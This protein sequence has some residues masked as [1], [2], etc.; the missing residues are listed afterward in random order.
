MKYLLLLLLCSVGISAQVDYTLDEAE[1]GSLSELR[2]KTKVFIPATD[3][4]VRQIIIEKLRD[5]PFQVV[6]TRAESEFGLRLILTQQDVGSNVLLGSSHNIIV[7]C[8]M[9][10]YTYLPA[11]SGSGKGRV[12][13]LFQTRKKQDFSGGI[14]FDKHPAKSAMGEFLKALKKVTPS[15]PQL[16]SAWP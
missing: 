7:F 3:M 11:P 4:K 13:V 9:Y 12:R 14:T 2:G 8:D 6:S 15:S 5:T 10:V 1:Y 16:Q